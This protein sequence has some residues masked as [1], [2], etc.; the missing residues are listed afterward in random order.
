M[1][2]SSRLCQL[3]NIM[4]FNSGFKLIE[5]RFLFKNTYIQK[6]LRQINLQLHM[7]FGQ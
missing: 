3:S 1:L 2:I 5:P 7:L 4:P 6:R